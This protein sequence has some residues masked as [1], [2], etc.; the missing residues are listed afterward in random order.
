MADKQENKAPPSIDDKIDLLDDT[1][2]W[3]KLSVPESVAEL[4]HAS[5]F[6]T[7][8]KTQVAAIKPILC[9]HNRSGLL[10]APTGTGKTVSFLTVVMSH[11]VPDKHLPQAVIIAPTKLLCRQIY[12]VAEQITKGSNIHISL[13]LAKDELNEG[14]LRPT[15]HIVIGTIHSLLNNFS[16]RIVVKGKTRVAEKAIFDCNAINTIILDEADYFIDSK[17]EISKFIEIAPKKTRRY[18]YSATMPEEI[19]DTMVKEWLDVDNPYF[20]ERVNIYL[21]NSIQF[22]LSCTEA[23]KTVALDKVVNLEIYKKGAQSI[24]FC[25]TRKFVDECYEV[26]KNAGYSCS[27]YHSDMRKEER[28]A[29]FEKFKRRESNCLIT[30]D[31]LAR[32]I[33]VATIRLVVNYNP[34]I[35]WTDSGSEAAD[36]IIYTHRIGRGG[37]FGKA[38]VSITLYEKDTEKAYMDEIIKHIDEKYATQKR[39][40][41]VITPLESIDA[42]KEKVELIVKRVDDEIS[43][44]I[45]EQNK[46]AE[47]RNE[48]GK[49]EKRDGVEDLEL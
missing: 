15:A 30:T 34:P 37:R 24:V 11:V 38:T 8:T 14:E 47:R 49:A 26:M 9:D 3:E 7:P 17:H 40:E 1:M 46:R 18:L 43:K 19:V 21:G 22:S 5:S 13:C 39:T 41:H 33:D 16:G 20:V 32:G 44:E 6:H 42:I 4:L 10:E 31:G 48:G 12:N 45:D 29:E 27:R 2:T 28:T 35:K 36:P 23:E 25:K